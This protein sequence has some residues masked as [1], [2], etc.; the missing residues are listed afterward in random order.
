VK[1]GRVSKKNENSEGVGGKLGE[2]LGDIKAPINVGGLSVMSTTFT[3]AGVKIFIGRDHSGFPHLLLPQV[4]NQG[5]EIT[6]I[7]ALVSASNREWANPDGSSQPYLDI[8]CESTSADV[9]FAAMSLSICEQLD[10]GQV[11]STNSLM[12]AVSDQVAHWRAILEA[13]SVIEASASEKLGLIGE[14][15]TLEA[16]AVKDGPVVFE[17]WF[18]QEK[19]RHDFEFADRAFEIKASTRT[20]GIYCTVH[21]LN[22][23]AKA[24]GTSLNLVHF[25]LEWSGGG[26]SISKLLNRLELL[27][28]PRSQ[29]Q[30][31]LAETWKSLTEPPRWFDH[32]EFKVIRCST[33]LVDEN[34]PAISQSTIGNE[35]ASIVSNLQYTLNLTGITPKC[36]TSESMSIEKVVNFA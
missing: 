6:Q 20:S 2:L 9:L 12:K 36:E 18:G 24:P 35:I 31:K 22:Q 32:Y 10:K 15:L 16:L 28:I 34:F 33:Y 11:P 7:A 1:E 4:T 13:I 3:L 5:G 17:S 23:L 29:V 27:G 25:Q 30:S 21:G 8:V 19:S 14:L 26:D